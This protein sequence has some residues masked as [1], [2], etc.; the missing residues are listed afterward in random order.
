QNAYGT[1]FGSTLSFTTTTIYVPPTPPTPVPPVIINNNT[2]TFVGGGTG[3][4]YVMLKITP[5]FETVSAGDTITFTVEYRNISGKS[6]K[7]SILR[8][9]MPVELQFKRSTKGIFSSS[10][11][12]LTLELGTLLPNDHDTF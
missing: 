5:D 4:P 11:N 8:V 9:I 2:T 10:D 6:L 7:N 12:A 3:N 1:D